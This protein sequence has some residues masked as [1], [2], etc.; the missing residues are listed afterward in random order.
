MT[1]YAAPFNLQGGYDVYAKVTATN[2]YGTSE[3]SDPGNG[4]AIVLV[5]DAPYQVR[6]NAAVTSS[7]QVGLTWIDGI[8]NGGRPVIDYTLSYDQSTGTWIE[9][10]SGITA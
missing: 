8:S 7:T 4:A 9:L 1:L 5:P 10:E 6:D 2:F 3:D